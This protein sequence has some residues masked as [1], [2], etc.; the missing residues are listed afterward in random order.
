VIA[1]LPTKEQAVAALALVLA[2]A[3]VR[4]RQEVPVAVV[5]LPKPPPREAPALV[6]KD[7]IAVARPRLVPDA[8]ATEGR[9]PF[10]AS[11]IWE[12]PVPV[13]IALPPE[14]PETRVVPYI[15]LDEGRVRAP[16]PPLVGALPKP[17]P[18]AA[19]APSSEGTTD[20]MTAPG[21]GGGKP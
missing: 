1:L 8:R 10:A 13:P 21:A 7:E 3:T 12:D 2:L 16:R 14:L 18:E 4:S 19:P 9:D 11:D 15:S 17:L 20:P 6:D 5:P